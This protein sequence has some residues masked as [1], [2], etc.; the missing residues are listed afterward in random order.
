MCLPGA[1]EPRLQ[2]LVSARDTGHGASVQIC[3]KGYDL[4]QSMGK[5]TWKSALQKGSD[6]INSAATGKGKLVDPLRTG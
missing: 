2:D 6:C 5:V 4:Q 3:T 1:L